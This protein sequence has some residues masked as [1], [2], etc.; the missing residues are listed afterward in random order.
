MKSVC[1]PDKQHVRKYLYIHIISI[2]TYHIYFVAVATNLYRKSLKSSLP[3][4]SPCC[5][6]HPW[7]PESRVT[8][9]NIHLGEGKKSTFHLSKPRKSRKKYCHFW[10][11]AVMVMVYPPEK[12]QKTCLKMFPDGRL[13]HHGFDGLP[14]LMF[15]RLVEINWYM[16]PTF[17]YCLH[18]Y[19][20]RSFVFRIY[21]VY[22]HMYS[23]PIWLWK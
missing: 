10:T 21:D 16:A 23:M 15:L 4:A 11:T 9:T 19:T 8:S 6:S 3:F 20:L 18:W 12:N 7:D 14:D 5:K 13:W 22:I 17:A 2:K 1:T